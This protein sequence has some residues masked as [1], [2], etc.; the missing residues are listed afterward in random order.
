MKDRK[1]EVVLAVAVIVVGTSAALSARQGCSGG[2]GD[3]AMYVAPATICTAAPCNWV[4]IHTD[5]AFA[6]VEDVAVAV[7]GEGVV[8]ANA[9]ADDRGNLVVQL[10]FEDVA[11]IV[12]PP[13]ATVDLALD[14]AGRTLSASQSVRV[15]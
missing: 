15:R 5:V 4:T 10:A 9:F 7:D 11:A 1:I 6:S 8:V 12:V 13:A 14:V 3:F 2:Q